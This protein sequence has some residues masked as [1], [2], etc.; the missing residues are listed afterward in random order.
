MIYVYTHPAEERI[1]CIH[2]KNRNVELAANTNYKEYIIPD[3]FN[4]DKIVKDEN[5]N[6]ITLSNGISYDEFIAKFNGDYSANRVSQYPSIEEQLDMQY[7]D[8][9]NG[10]TN[11]KDTIAKIKSDNPKT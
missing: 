3:N 4:L 6:D 10:T 5:G 1:L 9:V 2:M 8:S 7:W 11:W